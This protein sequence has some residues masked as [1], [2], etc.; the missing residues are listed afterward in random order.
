VKITVK[1][2]GTL[3]QSYPGYIHSEGIVVKIPDNGKVKDLLS[4]LKLPE[5]QDVAV[6]VDGRILARDDELRND[7]FVN[8][9]QSL[10]GG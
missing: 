6:V 4:A 2:Y 7:A 1:L 5:S 8:I 3:G 10:H 9:M